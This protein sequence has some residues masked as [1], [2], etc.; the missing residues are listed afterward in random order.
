MSLGVE[1]L[2]TDDEERAL[3]IAQQLDELNRKRREI[4]NDM[5]DSVL[6]DID[7]IEAKE[8]YSLCLYDEAWHPG[9]IGI[10]AARM[11]DRL[12]RPVLAF[13]PGN[14]DELKGSGRSIPGLHL[15]DALDLVT[16]RYPGLVVRFGGHAAA[17][18]VSIFRNKF[19]DFTQAFE[20]TAQT[21][22]SPSDLQRLIETDGSLDTQDMTLDLAR[23]LQT[24]V[25][26]QGFPQPQFCDEFMVD[27]QRVVGGKHLKL[28][29]SKSN[30]V[31]DAILFSKQEILPNSIRAVYRVD[32]NEYQNLESL[33][34]VVHHWQPI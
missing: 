31:F 20:E 7:R 8:S 18:G 10:L 13:A 4:Q 15:R 30:R 1:C 23:M 29:L 16:K 27:A 28:K 6:R 3:N 17:A 11:K 12:H 24:L 21:L 9:I 2:I 22:L 5:Q 14:D 25:W 32:V 33:Q 19:N 34:L 26:G